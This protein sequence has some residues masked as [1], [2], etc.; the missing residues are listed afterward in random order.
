MRR[1]RSAFTLTELLV[2]MGIAIT[3]VAFALRW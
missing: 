3:L 1:H 2:S